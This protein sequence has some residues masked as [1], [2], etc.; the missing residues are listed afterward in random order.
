MMSDA[1]DGSTEGLV[2]SFKSLHS[3]SEFF[4]AEP[5]EERLS[6]LTFTYVDEDDNAFFGSATCAKRDPTLRLVNDSLKRIPDEDIFSIPPEDT[7]LADVTSR[8]GYYLKRPNLSNYGRLKGLNI[9]PKILLDEIQVLE[10]LKKN[11]HPNLVYYLGSVIK[12]GRIIGFALTKYLQTIEARLRKD[13]ASFD[14]IGAIKGI[15][16]AVEHLHSLGLA[17]NDLNPAN[18]MVDNH[19]HVVIIDLGS[20]R[21]F[22]Q[23]LISGGTRGWVEQNLDTSEKENDKIA[24]RKIRAWAEGMIGSVEQDD[25]E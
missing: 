5:G 20:C 3:L 25:Q 13:P 24:L 2:R 10:L 7:T 16:S 21:P 22:G 12:R 19:D 6:H 4:I 11:P 23:K 18:I 1:K 15:E 9:I 8:N 17:Y 14:T